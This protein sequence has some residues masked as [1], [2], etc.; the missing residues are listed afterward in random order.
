M[1]R[2]LRALHL[3]TAVFAVAFLAMYAISALQMA[4]F[5]WFNIKPV[6]SAHD[7]RLAPSLA[8]ARPVAVALAPY[9]VRGE[10]RAIEW[11]GGDLRL[12]LVSTGATH[13]VTYKPTGEAHVKTSANGLQAQ[14]NALHRVAGL[15]PITASLALFLLGATGLCL[16][17]QA[18]RERLRGVM[19]LA[20]ACAFVIFLLTAIRFS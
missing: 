16:W 12:R 4:H 19:L 18:H 11:K 5:R 15:L 10:L 1:F 9:G 14:L 13:E 6:V 7:Y 8:G 17:W 3:C 2:N 20:G